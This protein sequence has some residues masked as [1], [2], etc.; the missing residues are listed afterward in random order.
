M[1]FCEH[2]C[3]QLLPEFICP[4]LLYMNTYLRDNIYK[5][6]H[7]IDLCWLDFARALSSQVVAMSSLV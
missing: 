6:L 4:A 2:I 3:V 5:M 1:Y 7:K